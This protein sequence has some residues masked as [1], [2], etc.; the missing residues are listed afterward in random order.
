MLVADM[1][2]QLKEQYPDSSKKD[3]MKIIN[4]KWQSL[5]KEE[6]ETFHVRARESMLKRQMKKYGRQLAYMDVK[7]GEEE[8]ETNDTD[9]NQEIRT[10]AGTESSTQENKDAGKVKKK[11]KA[12]GYAL[13]VKE[14]YK[15]TSK[16]HPNKSRLEVYQL[17][18][19]KWASLSREE[20]LVYNRKASGGPLRPKKT[21]IKGGIRVTN[22]MQQNPLGKRPKKTKL[23]RAYSTGYNIFSKDAYPNIR[24]ANPGMPHIELMKIVGKH[25][26]ALDSA[27]QDKYVKEA[28]E[29]REKRIA[30]GSLVESSS[31]KDVH[32]ESRGE[33]SDQAIN[34]PGYKEENQISC[35]KKSLHNHMTPQ[36]Y[37]CP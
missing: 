4:E 29:R 32:A 15:L 6:Q 37:Q 5:T 17:I 14:W 20:Q 12:F 18:H 11:K 27:N 19:D 23:A 3:L 33:T 26:K 35:Q 1:H 8:E 28:L 9:R 21:S 31:N 13:F 24:K 22:D 30:D 7:E 2:G 36:M 16:V 25:W 10:N 34:G